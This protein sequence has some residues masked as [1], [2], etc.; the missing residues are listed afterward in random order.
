M[1]PSRTSSSCGILNSNSLEG[2][3]LAILSSWQLQNITMHNETLE[4]ESPSNLGDY[5]DL[6]KLSLTD[7]TLIECILH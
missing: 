7:S 1:D 5:L 3:I 6:E 4:G 2:S